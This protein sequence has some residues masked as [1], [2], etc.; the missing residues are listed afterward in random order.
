[1]YD[2]LFI[3]GLILGFS[4]AAAVGP[5]GILCIQRSLSLGFAVGLATG[6]GAA[7]AD[8]IYGAVAALGLTLITNFMVAQTQLLGLA[9]GLFL[10]YLG[11]RTFRSVPAA[12]AAQAQG[13]SLAGAYGSSLF[14]T[15][16]NPLTILSFTLIFGGLGLG[17]TTHNTSAA[18][19]LVAGV[20]LGS[21]LWWLLLS[22]G[23]SLFRAR[24]DVPK[25]RWINRLSGVVI[26]AFGGVILLNLGLQIFS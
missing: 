9:G 21:G 4:I 25:L 15:L 22:G 8:A 7:T 10:G 19:L 26:F 2:N 16:T 20:F 5:I 13:D 17:H 24:L 12:T 1:M 11:V 23:V 3:N 18:V 14:L 6:L